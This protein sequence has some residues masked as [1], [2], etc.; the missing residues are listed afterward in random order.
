VLE[1]SAGDERFELVAHESW[2]RARAFFEPLSERGPVLANEGEGVAALGGPRNVAGLGMTTG[3]CTA[4]P[5][6]IP[7]HS[8]TGIFEG[9]CAARG[10][11]RG[12]RAGRPTAS[13]ATPPLNPS[14]NETA[15]ITVLKV[16]FVF[17]APVGPQ[18]VLR[19]LGT[20]R[21]RDPVM[22]GRRAEALASRI[23]VPFQSLI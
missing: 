1:V 9:G 23:G 3:H 2:Q 7:G 5:M 10:S 17:L 19:V 4:L 20:Q 6:R 18:P 13:L 21:W 12:P 22:P 14:R 11:P 8:R 15:M 16:F